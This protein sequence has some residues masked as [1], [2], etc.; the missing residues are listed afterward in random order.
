MLQNSSERKLL[1]LVHHFK[2]WCFDLNLILW[3]VK[4][5]FPKSIELDVDDEGALLQQVAKLRLESDDD[6][7][8]FHFSIERPTKKCFFRSNRR[9]WRHTRSIARRLATTRINAVVSTLFVANVLQYWWV[10][11]W[12]TGGL[13]RLILCFML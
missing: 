9:A 1:S 8:S 5:N 3:I 11:R 13:I 4:H 10:E 2:T 7:K 6:S 12:N